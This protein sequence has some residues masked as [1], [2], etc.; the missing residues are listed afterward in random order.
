MLKFKAKNLDGQEVKFSFEDIGT[1]YK[2]DGV[3]FITNQ[4]SAPCD[5]KSV[6]L[7]KEE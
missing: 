3:F 2:A 7:I 5:I 6:Q 1:V 4:P